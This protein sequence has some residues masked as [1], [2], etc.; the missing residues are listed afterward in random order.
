MGADPSCPIRHPNPQANFYPSVFYELSPFVYDGTNIH[1]SVHGMTPL[2]LCMGMVSQSQEA[3]NC[4]ALLISNGANI[5][6]LAHNGDTPLDTVL[7]HLRGT[8]SFSAMYDVYLKNTFPSILLLGSCGAFANNN[9]DILQKISPSMRRVSDTDIGTRLHTTSDNAR[10]ERARAEHERFNQSV[11]HATP[12]TPHH[13]SNA[14]ENAFAAPAP[15]PQAEQD[16]ALFNLSQMIVY[17]PREV[18]AEI[19]SYLSGPQNAI[20]AHKPAWLLQNA[21]QVEA[22]TERDTPTG[23]E[24]KP[25]L[26]QDTGFVSQLGS[27]HLP[28]RQVAPQELVSPNTTTSTSTQGFD[29]SYAAKVLKDQYKDKPVKKIIEKKEKKERKE[30]EKEEKEAKKLQKQQEKEEKKAKKYADIHPKKD[31]SDRGPGGGQGTSRL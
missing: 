11:V 25:P 4:T 3:Q 26:S 15:K 18:Q 1:K 24:T 2:H 17:L 27:S 10:Q 9:L 20:T 12:R 19:A 13:P 28:L 16:P 14:W 31:P 8:G 7:N 22:Q 23:K 30:H 29:T 21:Q 5:N 6:A